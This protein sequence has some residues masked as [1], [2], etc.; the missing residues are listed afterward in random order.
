MCE[1]KTKAF[2]GFSTK[3][4]MS[5]HALTA[6]IRVAHLAVV[7]RFFHTVEEE[8]EHRIWWIFFVNCRAHTPALLSF[9]CCISLVAQRTLFG[10]SQ[11]RPELRCKRTVT[12]IF[13][14]FLI[15]SAL[16]PYLSIDVWHHP[17]VSTSACVPSH[18]LRDS[19]IRSY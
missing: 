13:Y 14:G 1:R 3:V 4:L 6:T 2:S 8:K 15:I 16:A 12:L 7:H 11:A 19:N 9:Y 10:C 18:S 17:S 5:A